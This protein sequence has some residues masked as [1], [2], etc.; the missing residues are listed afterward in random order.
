MK[1]YIFFFNVNRL[2]DN[3]QC[4]FNKSVSA[5][6]TADKKNMNYRKYIIILFETVLS[7]TE[8]V[9]RYFLFWGKTVHTALDI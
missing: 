2:S 3:K 8:N 1:I 5:G 6:S 7:I 4:Y 9:G